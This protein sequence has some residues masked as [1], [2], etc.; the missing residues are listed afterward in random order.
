M[1]K[2]Q[3]FSSETLFSF[4][5]GWRY[6]S[7]VAARAAENSRWP[8][9]GGGGVAGCSGGGAAGGG[10]R[11]RVMHNRQQAVG[12]PALDMPRQIEHR[13]VARADR[14]IGPRN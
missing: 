4:S 9:W 10:L 13:A 2:C 1:S 7:W 3:R 11:V 14:A 8:G 12:Q 5:S 6:S